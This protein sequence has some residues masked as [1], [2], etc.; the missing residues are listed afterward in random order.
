MKGKTGLWMLVV[1][2][3]LG[4]AM[5]ACSGNFEQNPDGSWAVESQTDES[6]IQEAID[7]AIVD[8][9]IKNITVDLR[10]G[11]IFVTADRERFDGSAT[12]TMTFRLDLGVGEGHLTASVSD[13]KVNGEPVDE[14]RVELW[15]ERIANRLERMARRFPNSTLESLSIGGDLLTTV[16][17]V[18][19]RK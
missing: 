17:R 16:W 19:P 15:N 13:V 7:E 6:S 2:I 11:Y 10:E 1:I 8:P 3:V 12:D 4:L 14:D 9:L 5:G 18:E